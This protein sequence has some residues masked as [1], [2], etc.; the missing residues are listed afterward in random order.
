[1]SNLNL[2]QWV[3]TKW[4]SR[5]QLEGGE[6]ISEDLSSRGWHFNKGYNL[7]TSPQQSSP[8]IHPL[9]TKIPTEGIVPPSPSGQTS[10]AK[11]TQPLLKPCVMSTFIYKQVPAIFEG[12]HAAKNSTEIKDFYL[13]TEFSQPQHFH[14][15]VFIMHVL[16]YI[17]SFIHESSF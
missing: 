15:I 9:Q 7:L 4:R 12:T 2:A 3:G 17:I 6:Q 16:R 11:E 5:K 8:I 13:L 10:H 14:R 1:M